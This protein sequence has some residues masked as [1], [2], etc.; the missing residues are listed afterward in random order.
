M[1]SFEDHCLESLAHF[2]N[3]YPDVHRWLDEYAGCPPHGMRHRRLRH[4]TAGIVETIRRFGPQA[5]L[6]ARQH[7]L[8]DLKQEGWTEADPFP[9][10]EAH[11]VVMGLF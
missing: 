3:A 8:T 10:D 9:R 7:I 5:G 1:S 6:A 2:G 11:Y 4:H